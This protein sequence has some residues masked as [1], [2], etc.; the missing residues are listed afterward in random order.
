MFLQDKTEWR[1]VA[2]LVVCYGSIGLMVFNPLALPLWGQAVI[3]I[4]L[5]TLHS[6]LQ[7]EYMH[8]HPF[9]A[10]K[11]NDI[12]VWL[13]VG[14][15]LPY[16]RFKAAHLKH[17][18]DS[19]ICDPLE[20]PES[21]Y[22]DQEVWDS[23]PRWV[24][25]IFEVNNTF[26]G[27]MVLGPAISVISFTYHEMTH[28]NGKNGIIWV[29]HL[30]AVFGLL[31]GLHSIGELPIWVYLLC[32]Y[33]GYS[34]LMV[35]TFLEHR[36]HELEAARTVIV[37]D[38]GIFSYLFLN[39]NLHVV[40]HTYP[41]LAWYQLPQK[42]EEKRSHFLSLNKGYYYKNYLEVFRQFALKQKEP[43]RFPMEVRTETR[44][45]SAQ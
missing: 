22:K 13:P 7:H 20:D 40:H 17:H 42:F 27:R 44:E 16:F 29:L 1:T 6:S 12:L 41:R 24:Q 39:N 9:T 35:R 38:K 3:L 8:G 26:L 5:I 15:F 32:C 10:Q 36:A 23:K 37:E 2:L 19:Q 25:K 33:G 45:L 4:P 21:W 18:L 31:A 14:I 34:L 30:G 43:V 11:L 28:L